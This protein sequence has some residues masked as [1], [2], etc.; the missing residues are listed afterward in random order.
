MT[1]QNRPFA[2]PFHSGDGLGCNYYRIPALITTQQGVTIAAM[3]ARFGGLHDSPNN[4]DTALSLSNDC[5]KTWS[6]PTLPFHLVDYA[7]SDARLP[8]RNGAMATKPSASTID[9]CLLEDRE[10]GRIFLLVD[11]FP[12]GFGSLQAKTG[13]GYAQIGGE[14]C[15]RLRKKG[16]LSFRYY[17]R[18]DG[19]ICSQDGQPTAYSLNAEYELLE[20]GKPLFVRQ[21]RAIVGK[22]LVRTKKTDIKVPMHL[23]YADSLFQAEKTSYLFLRYSDDQG[24]TWSSPISLNAMVKSPDMRVLVTGPGCGVQLRGGEHA[25]R[26]LFPVYHV[27]A[28]FREQSCMVIYSDDHGGTWH[29][30]GGPRYGREIGMMSE[31]QLVELPDGSVQVFARTKAGRV[32]TA[33]SAD[34]GITWS[35]GALVPGLP[36]AGG[37]GCQLS[38]IPYGGCI[39]GK[40][41]V[42]VSPPAGPGRKHGMVHIGLIDRKEGAA[43]PYTFAWNYHFAITGP[44]QSFA[45]SCL[46][47]LPDDRIGI[48]YEEIDQAQSVD[49]TRFEAISMETLLAEK[50]SL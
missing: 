32:A 40:P 3:D 15:L 27:T 29:L 46:T 18:P 20:N 33:H 5:G 49:T 50:D 31:S 10:T 25:G 37:S 42:L 8:L 12:G 43:A 44:E 13:S 16:S 6:K 45:Y 36:L 21:R 1:Q 48:L 47:Q 23:F 26:L 4:L 2:I 35:D 7:D 30:G 19:M 34:G 14:A 11:M 22:T 39:D 9:P 38:A 24:K 41:P 17:V 28:G